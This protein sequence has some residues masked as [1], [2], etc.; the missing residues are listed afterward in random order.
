[1]SVQAGILSFD[2]E[3]IARDS[4]TRIGGSLAEYGPDGETTYCDGPLGLLYRPFHTTEESTM[5]RQPHAS[6]GGNIVSFDGRL[7]NRE[8]LMLQL[9]G[10]LTGDKTDV[11]IVATAFDRWGTDCFAR[12]VGDWAISVWNHRHRELVL[13]RDY[14]GI[15][16]LFYHLSPDRVTWCSHLAPLALCR[17]NLTLCDRYIAG[18]LAFDP[19]AHLTPYQEISAVPPG[20][21]VRIQRAKLTIHRF[22][23]YNTKRPLRYRTDAEYEEHYRYLFCQSVRRRL[24]TRSA[25]LADLSGGFDSTS[26]V[27]MADQILKKE[28]AETRRVDTFSFYD[29]AEPD[30]D[31]LRHLT[32]VENHRGR[33]G[34]RVNLK[35]CGDSL[36]FG[37]APFAASPNFA[38]RAEIKVAVSQ[39]LQEHKYR[40]VLSGRGGDE[41]NG[42]ALNPRVQM[43]DLLLHLRFVELAKQLTAWS[44]LIRKRPW[45]QLLFQ[46]LLQLAPTRIHA[47]LSQQG[48]I[49]PWISPA[50]AKQHGMSALQMGSTTGVSSV[51]PSV[52][53]AV[54]TIVTLSR[55]T[56]SLEPSVIENRYPYLDQQLVEF[57]TTIPLDQL[58]RPGQ[59]RSLMRRS[60][61]E[62]LPSDVLARKTKSQVSRC[63]AVTL[64]KHWKEVEHLLDRPV[65]SGCGY[66]LTAPLRD[67]LVAVKNGQTSPYLLRLLRAI[68]LEIWLRS[69]E[70]HGVIGVHHSSAERVLGRARGEP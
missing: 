18:Y 2:G 8:E 25:I 63:F 58:L 32:K 43:A 27:C 28:G 56:S 48:K 67:A 39:I 52:R 66:F 50:F 40:V 41:F 22:W 13:A 1:M 57:L 7:D 51:L 15:R 26:I 30:E 60:L 38:G 21:F 61:A 35:G 12:L 42:Q 69:A 59:R 54:H 64:E 9:S 36:L 49:D 65:S 17:K 47:R 16:H 6:T 24:R 3:P 44:L 5:E 45:I 34:F 11:G 20:Q 53:D 46:T 31:D 70:A 19:E 33:A 55:Q 37:D 23:F 4:L 14:M 68:T 29:P 62:L 10:A